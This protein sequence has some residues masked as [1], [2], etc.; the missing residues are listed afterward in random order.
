MSDWF[1]SYGFADILDNLFIGAYPLDEADVAMLERLG[2]KR[3]LNLVEDDEY[4]EGE[5]EAVQRS[6]AAAGIEEHRHSL[7][8][9]GELPPEALDAAVHEVSGWIEEGVR[10]YVHCRAGWQRSAAIAAGVVALQ[11]GSRS[12]RRC[13][14]SSSASHPLIR[15]PT[16]ARTSAAGGRAATAATRGSRRLATPSPASLLRRPAATPSPGSLL[17]ARS[18]RASSAR[19]WRRAPT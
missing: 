16:S 2:I 17:A 12:T 14:T 6:L 19:A 8:D 9:Y 11:A 3:I 4:G 18:R 5:R 1:R 13:P 10:T 15:F 7:I